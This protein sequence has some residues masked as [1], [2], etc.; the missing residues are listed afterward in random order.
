MTAIQ[1]P[2]GSNRGKHNFMGNASLINCHAEIGGD[3][4]RARY[5]IVQSDGLTP[6]ETGID[7]PTRGA[8]YLPDLELIYSAHS[9]SLWKIDSTGA[10]TL[11]GAIPGI[12]RVEIVRNQKATPQIGIRCDAGVYIGEGDVVAPL[13][14]GDIPAVDNRA[15]RRAPAM[16]SLIRALAGVSAW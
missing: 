9:S 6:F 15:A 12:D 8:I 2:F 10:E 16:L 3:Q 13:A 1:T 7:T 4:G 14:D 11:V 5:S